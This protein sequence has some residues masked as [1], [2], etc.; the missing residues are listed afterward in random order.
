M[1]WRAASRA[2]DGINL[3]AKHCKHLPL[4][5]PIIL[6]LEWNLEGTVKPTLIFYGVFHDVLLQGIELVKK[7]LLIDF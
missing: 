6:V 1:S 3:P 5:W 2:R 4:S 7:S